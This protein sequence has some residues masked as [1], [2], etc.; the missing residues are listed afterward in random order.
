MNSSPNS[1]YKSPQTD[2]EGGGNDTSGRFLAYS[3]CS[4]RGVET[5]DEHSAGQTSLEQ[6]VKSVG[7]YVST[8][9]ERIYAYTRP[10]E[11]LFQ[12]IMKHRVLRRRPSRCKMQWIEK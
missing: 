7:E 8:N 2:L 9:A 3:V 12:M 4:G 5:V 10:P 6:K 11:R 1:C